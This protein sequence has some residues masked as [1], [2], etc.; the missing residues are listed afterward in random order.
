MAFA[1]IVFSFI[2]G[3]YILKYIKRVNS[4]F[5]GSIFTTLYLLGLGCLDFIT[6]KSWII[7]CSF[8]CQVLGGI[9]SGMMWS[10]SMAILSGFEENRQLYIGYYEIGAS[11][12]ILV[13]PVIG[14]LLYSFVGYQGPFFTIMAIYILFLIYSLN[15]FKDLV[16][17]K[18]EL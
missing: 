11:M 10:S 17:K 3:M 9:G 13:G 1:V 7:F 4:V 6:D 15:K 14:V 8:L 16:F 12:G 2:N 5:I 18:E